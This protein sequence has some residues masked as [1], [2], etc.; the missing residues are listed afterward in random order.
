MADVNTALTT[1]GYTVTQN[2]G[3]PGTFTSYKQV[4][5]LRVNGTAISA[6]EI[7]AY[8]NYLS[9]GGSL[10]IAG[11]NA[12]FFATRDT[13]IANLVLA[14][15]GGTITPVNAGSTQ[16]VVLA[17]FTT[18][19]YSVSTV[20]LPVP[21]GSASPGTGAFIS[22]DS[23]NIGASIL[24]GSIALGKPGT[25]I[26][27]FDWDF[28][29]NAYVG[30]GSD[31]IA[32]EYLYNLIGYLGS[33][34]PYITSLTPNSGPIGASVVI[35]GGNFGATQGTSKV[36]FNGT[37]AT[38]VTAWGPNSITANVP[39]GTTTGNVTVVVN[40]V[41]SNGV[42]FTVTGTTSVPTLSQGAFLLLAC[43][44]IG[45]AAWRIG[46]SYRPSDI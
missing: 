35:A 6:G 16:T 21:G 23:S 36:Y 42:L 34:G 14:V 45:I 33:P 7:A 19:P 3:L 46:R 13:S 26:V 31:P 11:E 44:L 38:T 28:L 27:V 29:N 20:T 30:P 5:D 17:P 24:W 40:S 1:A 39:A 41:T 32:L 43:C 4:W 12:T 15:G 8:S 18:T 2:V 22:K 9:A 10:Y 25:L 37:L